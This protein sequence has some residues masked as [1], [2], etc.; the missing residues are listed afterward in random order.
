M[1]NAVR[2]DRPRKANQIRKHYCPIF[3]KK[4]SALSPATDNLGYL[5]RE[6]FHCIPKIHFITKVTRSGNYRFQ[7]FSLPHKIRST[8]KE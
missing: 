5:P 8:N 4:I 7:Y 6:G 3:S 2:V 1:N